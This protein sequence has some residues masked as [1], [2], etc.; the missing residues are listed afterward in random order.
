MKKVINKIKVFIKRLYMGIVKKTRVVLPVAINIVE[1]IKKVVDSPVDNVVSEIIANAIPGE[2][3]D[4][5]ITKSR[6]FIEN[7]LPQVLTQ[8]VI[9]DSISNIDNPNDQLKVIL[10]KLKLSSDET[11]AVVYHGL[12]SLILTDLSDGKLTWSES[13][14][15]SEYY[16]SKI[17][18]PQK[19]N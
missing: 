10:D 14:E 16:Y 5:I 8:L 4:A 9:I 17:I 7:V 19:L 13:V 1:T 3:D 18:K 15:I 11:K 6:L 12:A 2:A